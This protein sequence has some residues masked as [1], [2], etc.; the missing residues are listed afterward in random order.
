MEQGVNFG[1]YRFDA[2][3]GRLWA[4]A[5]EIRITPKASDVLK[6]LVSRAGEPVS[7]EDIFASVWTGI[8]VSDD[9]LTTCIRELRKA[10]DDDAKEPK[11][12]ETRHRRGYR[13]VAPLT[14]VPSSA[15]AAATAPASSPT[16]DSTAIAVLPF[17]DM[18]PERDQ[19][20]LCYGLA[21]ELI[22]ALTR[23]DGL[24]VVSR[25]ASF[26]FNNSGADVSEVGRLLRVGTL[27]EGSVRKADD[28][29]RIT[30]QLIDV[31]T[32]YHLL[33]E[34]FD[35]KLADVFAIQ[36]EI[37]DH[38]AASL[39]VA[40]LKEREKP[41]RPR[42]SAEAYEYY[43]R[44]KTILPRMT[45]QDLEKSVAL[46][47]RALEL[48]PNYSP[49]YACMSVA[50]G[51]LYEW[52]GGKNEHLKN[53]D[54]ASAKAMELSPGL[55]E[56]RLARGFALS[57]LK[58]H[59][60]ASKEFEKALR[61]NPNLFEAYYYYARDCF[62]R[63]DIE[64]SAELFRKAGDARRDDFQSPMLLAQSLTMLG[65]KQEALEAAREGIRRA[66][67]MLVLNPLDQRALSLGSGA[68]F[69]DDQ[70]ARAKAWA[71][72]AMELYPDDMGALINRAC[73][74][75]KMKEKEPALQLLERV[76]KKG[77]AKRDWLEH[78]P[79]YDIIRAD[80]RFKKMMATLK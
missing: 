31:A 61:L 6:V 44:A 51:T 9:A 14:T 78:D 75:L 58:K 41:A 80:P 40:I 54:F 26:Q 55:A 46:F 16:V 57:L 43:L 66:E 38:V 39:R 53:A 2:D 1:R 7:K 37:A 17:T 30:A 74:H 18:S 59:K 77:W 76:F 72:K 19:E 12:I 63:G 64:R 71:D 8:A 52:F 35:R 13:F 5:R 11:Y 21:E 42:T 29:L 25:T 28:R 56:S 68:L 33:S 4:G 32:G 23:I 47:E 65:R 62:A 69:L 67:Q 22:N 27:L 70:I 36:D 10:L 49:A 34:R 3:S 73:L 50:L 20:Y 24:R 48:D 45:E 15:T 60:D 79:D